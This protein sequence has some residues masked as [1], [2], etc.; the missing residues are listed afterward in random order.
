MYP[1][2]EH[3]HENE[4]AQDP[5]S[6]VLRASVFGASDGLVSNLAL[7]MGVA[8]GSN[9]PSLVILAGIAGLLAG[10]FSMGAGEYV[11]MQT[12]RELLEHEL[13][14]EREHIQNYPEE[15]QSHLAELLSANGLEPE[16]AERVAA[17]IHRRIEP[18]L[19]FHALFELGIHPGSLGSPRAAACWSF[20][21]FALGASVPLFPW[22]L[23][24]DALLATLGVSALALLAI[25]TAAAVLTHQRPWYGAGRQLLVGALAAAVTFAVGSLVG[26][27][28]G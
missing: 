26:V 24:P 13:E 21:S 5:Q 2:G 14:V 22:L 18:A 3:A 20:V 9:D 15:E 10:A 11:S 25:G 28:A 19:G 27:S 6:G 8:G 12:Q 1:R 16:D 23:S 4:H 7:V 17:Q